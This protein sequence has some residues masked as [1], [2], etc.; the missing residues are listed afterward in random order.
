MDTPAALAWVALDT[1]VVSPTLYRGFTHAGSVDRHVVSPTLYRGFTHA[2]SVDRHV[3]LPT[4]ASWFYPRNRP[5]NPH[6]T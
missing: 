5:H 2:S 1:I 3:V 4:H 6:D